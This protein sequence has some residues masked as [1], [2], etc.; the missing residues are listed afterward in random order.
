MAGENDK[1][2][3]RNIARDRT[4]QNQNKEYDEAYFKW[5][6]DESNP[7]SFNYV[8]DTREHSYTAGKGFTRHAADTAEQATLQNCL[9]LLGAVMLVMLLFDVL[10]YLLSIYINGGDLYNVIY[11]SER[12]SIRN[13]SIIPCVIFSAIGVLKYVAAII[14]YHAK[15][16]LP[17]KVA[18]PTG[19]PSGSFGFNSVII[20]LM[21][22][23]TGKISNSILAWILGF[24]NVD[25]VYIYMFNSTKISAQVISF[26]YNCIILPVLCE[27]FFRG[28]VLQSFRQFGDAFAVIV[29]A[30]SCGL[31]FCDVSYIGYAMLCSL[32][33]GVFTIRSGSIITAITMHSITT[34]VGYLLVFVGMISSS[35]GML[36]SNAIYIVICAG[37]L[38]AY[39]R[40]NRS[41]SW[42][43]NID[44][45]D[46]ELSLAKKM[47]IMLSS[48]TVAMWLVGAIVLTIMTMRILE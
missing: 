36:L 7:Y 22:V 19:N 28:L 29:S 41:K 10:G 43:F 8:Q 5:C 13:T 12:D 25:S 4:Y 2:F 44:R 30:I 17:F 46:S 16:K 1:S 23:V 37:A 26:L 32:V 33:I 15:N 18:M 31:S 9:R 11:Y 6:A 39:S 38:I 48:T 20:M 24:V 14:I 40:L 21:V 27:I 35:T 34:T 47:E 3:V 42:S 45:G